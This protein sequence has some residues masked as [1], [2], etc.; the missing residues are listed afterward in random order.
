MKVNDYLGTTDK[1]K[2]DTGVERHRYSQARVTIRE[3]ELM[4]GW[5]G[6]IP[7]LRKA[8]ICEGA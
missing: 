5:M 4:A 6:F 8:S 1:S 2:V 7:C 3:H